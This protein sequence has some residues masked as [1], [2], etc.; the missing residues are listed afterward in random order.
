MGWHLLPAANTLF[1]QEKTQCKRKPLSTS[2]FFPSLPA[3]SPCSPTRA[4]VLSQPT[5]VA[6]GAKGYVDVGQDKNGKTEST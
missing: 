5:S 6:P 2:F 1:S 3:F 4:N